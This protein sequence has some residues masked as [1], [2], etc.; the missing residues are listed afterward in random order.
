MR[1][2]EY[3][4]FLM[5]HNKLSNL[6]QHIFISSVSVGVES[7]IDYMSFLLRDSQGCNWGTSW[8]VLLWEAWGPLPSSCGRFQFLADETEVPIFLLAVTQGLLA[9]PRGCL[10]LPVIWPLTDPHI[11]VASFPQASRRLSLSLQPAKTESCITKLCNHRSD[12][13]SPL[14][15]HIGKKP[16]Q[17]NRQSILWKRWQMQIY[18]TWSRTWE[19]ACCVSSPLLLHGGMNSGL[20]IRVP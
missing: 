18:A 5:L 20:E 15:Y 7:G 9:V 3:I 17:W 19:E 2:S 10:Q 4:H 13:S 14:P 6:K 16:N 1:S 8:A 12:I 11:E